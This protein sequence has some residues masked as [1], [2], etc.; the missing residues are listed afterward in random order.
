M[1]GKAL[2]ISGGNAGAGTKI[3]MW[4]K[5]QQNAKNQLWYTDPQ[6]F[7]RSTLND[8]SFTNGGKHLVTNVNYIFD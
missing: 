6:G 1:N 5:H 7:I 8:M 2:D 3:I 4:D